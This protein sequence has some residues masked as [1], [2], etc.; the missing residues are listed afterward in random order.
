MPDRDYCKET[1]NKANEERIDA[2]VNALCERYTEITGKG[3]DDQKLW[4]EFYNIVR[5]Q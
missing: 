4:D 2:L 1:Y 5:F 3:K